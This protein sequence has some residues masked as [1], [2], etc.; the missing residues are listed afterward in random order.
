MEFK[1]MQ[2]LWMNHP[3]ADTDQL[4]WDDVSKRVR[5]LNR[6]VFVRD[7]MEFVVALG[8]AALFFW[9]GVLAP[10][11]WPWVGAGLLV[12]GVAAVFLRER[13]RAAR[14]TATAP[15]DVRGGLE[16]AIAEA[17]HQIHLLRSVATWYLAPVAA[18]VVL[19]LVGTVLG[20]RAEVGPEVWARGR[21]ALYLS[22]AAIVPLIG[23]VFVLVWWLNRRAVT[24]HLVP[25]R[26]SLVQAL[27][28]LDDTSDDEEV[29]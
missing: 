15:H 16:H 14:A 4:G 10:I 26:D 7:V 2:Q 5:T 28:Q 27:R 13:M 17:E 1:D 12:L 24:T 20:V 8:L 18:A 9:I 25:H 3:V 23:A 21:E 6:R 22:M 11:A 19:V 29:V